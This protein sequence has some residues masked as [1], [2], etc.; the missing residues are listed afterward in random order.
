MR[1]VVYDA[2]LQAP[3]IPDGCELADHDCLLPIKPSQ[4]SLELSNPLDRDSQHFFI[5]G[6][7]ADRRDIVMRNTGALSVS[8]S[9]HIEH[10]ANDPVI[11]PIHRNAPNHQSVMA[12]FIQLSFDDARSRDISVNCYAHSHSCE[13]IPRTTMKAQLSIEI[14][15]ALAVC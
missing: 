9:G 13:R 6:R 7:E 8:I 12:I 1:R 5:V 10:P 11:C 4:N 2:G 15:I 3:F 14:S